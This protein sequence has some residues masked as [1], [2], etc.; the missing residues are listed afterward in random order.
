VTGTGGVP[1]RGAGTPANSAAA[2]G[3]TGVDPGRL[4][5]ANAA[6]AAFY[7]RH[8]PGHAPALRYLAEHGITDAAG[9][10]LPWQLGYA[11]AAGWSTID[12]LHR[13]GFT[14]A[15]LIAAGLARQHGSGRT[16]AVFRDRVMF[17]IHGRQQRVIGFTARN[18]GP[19]GPKYLNTPDTAIYHKSRSLYGL[20]PLLRHPPP[21][22]GTALAIVV[23]GAADA[24][25]VQRMAAA[26]AR[27]PGAAPIYPIAT[28][29]TRLTAEH[30]ALLARTLP[31]GTD[32]CL[33]FDGDTAGRLAA[34]RA[35]PIA[36][37]WHGRRHGIVLPDG[38]DPA[39]LLATAA[40]PASAW[41]MFVAALRPLSLIRLEHAID[42]LVANQQI[43]DPARYPQDRTRVYAAIA[44]LFIDD[45]DNYQLLLA[46]TTERLHV[47][48]TEVARGVLHTWETR[49]ASSD[50]VSASPSP[51]NRAATTKARPAPPDPTVHGPGTSTPAARSSAIRTG[52]AGRQGNRGHRTDAVATSHDP[53][54]GR[55]AWALAD[56]IGDDPVSADAARMAA[57]IAAHAAARTTPTAGIQAARAT[58]NTV[59]AGQPTQQAG[60]AAIIVATTGQR[61][62]ENYIGF[63]IAWS[64]NCR[65]YTLT[66]DD[67]VQ[68]TDDH[69]LAQQLRCEGQD[70][71]TGSDLEHLLTASARSGTIA[72]TTL[73]APAG[74]LLL[75][76]AGIYRHA[77]PR[78]L[79]AALGPI[80]DPQA[81]ATRLI[82]GLPT[83]ARD[84]AAVLLLRTPPT[85]TQQKSVT[86]A[87]A[88]IGIAAV[89]ACFSSGAS[90]WPS[91]SQRVAT[92][93][94]T[95]MKAKGYHA[96][97]L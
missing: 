48:P 65:A 40:S 24:L 30:L 43:T 29:G 31:D 34:A 49:H 16:Y 1:P 50:A 44:E 56:G 6:A 18:L 14:D 85:H 7:A 3:A 87:T 84:N 41:K 80:R 62:G 69:T 75:C 42:E 15:E 19:R 90:V 13:A 93:P 71:P 2:A 88:P 58:L 61:T 66:G 86:A 72:H 38:H 32:L 51:D 67:L 77:D 79:T 23:E 17:P 10:R 20:G 45:P 89:R 21:G 60:D 97:H 57:Q 92:R 91:G 73:P 74:T 39:A 46:A 52:Y 83:N 8:L 26:V 9:P 63:E 4:Y 47:D 54:A 55:Q 68:L 70:I 11:P 12:H 22:T 35:Y 76:T 81:T 59:Y 94:G 33:A 64:G 37:R 27:Q 28:C 53:A 96:L 95:E 82:T 25:A 78:H 5:A 36:A